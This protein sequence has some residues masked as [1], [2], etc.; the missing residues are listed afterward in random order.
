M[1]SSKGLINHE[2]TSVLSAV[3][4]GGLGEETRRGCGLPPWS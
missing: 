2:V 3:D 4:Q 1:V